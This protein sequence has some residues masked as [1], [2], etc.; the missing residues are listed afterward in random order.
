MTRPLLLLGC[1]ALGL[2]GCGGSGD[3]ESS[4]EV[5]TPGFYRGVASGRAPQNGNG[6]T[7]APFSV[8]AI[9]AVNSTGALTVDTFLLERNEQYRLRAN[10]ISAPVTTARPAELIYPAGIT[11]GSLSFGTRSGVQYRFVATD[12][13]YE[14]D[15]DRIVLP[16]IGQTYDLKDG[17]YEGELFSTLRV[18]ETRGA[19]GE[20]GDYAVVIGDVVAGHFTGTV[21][22]FSQF[23]DLNLDLKAGGVI[24]NASYKRGPVVPE[25]TNP[26]WSGSGGTLDLAFDEAL[27]TGRTNIAVLRRTGD[28]GQ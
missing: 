9:A 4:S 18:A 26:R 10:A 5:V 12:V 23:G 28:V 6:G 11:E 3:A 20:P 24:V 17:H 27:N 19:V 16:K 22:T 14:A 25:I 2:I 7:V 13:T 21:R 15:L 1:L 8:S